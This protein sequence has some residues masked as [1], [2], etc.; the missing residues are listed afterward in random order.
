MRRARRRDDLISHLIDEGCNDR[1]ILGE[2]VTFAAAGMVTTREFITVAAWHL[3]TDDELRQRYRTGDERERFALLHE[4]LRLEPV[5]G[6]LF[7]RTTAD[8]R[9]GGTT[10]PSGALVDIGVTAANSDATAVGPEPQ[11]VC[12][13]RPL[14][15]GVGDAV[16]SFGD[17]AHRCPGAYIA[18][19]ESDIF[20]SRLFAQPGLRMTRPPEVR[21]RPEIAA[22]E[23]VRLI[24]EV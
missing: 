17:G 23:V 12:P 15:D 20:L 7:R 16:L 22:Y 14:A 1:E 18:I 19:Q 2:C 8:V 6:D 10:I 21:L 9:V 11:S 13:G 5:V 4:I 24:V 3:F